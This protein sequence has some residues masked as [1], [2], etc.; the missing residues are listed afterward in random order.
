MYRNLTL[1]VFVVAIS[2]RLLL[3]WGNSPENAFDNHYRPIALIV[4]TGK[5]PAKDDCFQ[6]YQPPV[7]YYSSAMAAKTLINLGIT[8]KEIIEKILQFINCIYVI[9]TIPL[10]YLILKKFGLSETS[11]LIAFSL[12]CFLPR[13]IFMSAM[14]SNDSLAYLGVSLCTYLLLVTIERG[15]PWPLA[16]LLGITVTLTIFVKYTAL[17]VLPMVAVPL[18]SLLFIKSAIPRAKTATAI[19]LA[20]LVPLI[21]YGNYM[22][23]NYR[24]YGKVLPWNDTMINTS[25]VQPHDQDWVSFASFT[26]WQYIVEPM[27]IPG[28]MHSFWTLVYSGMWVDNEPHFTQMTDRNVWW[29]DYFS[30]LR[31]GAA[32]PSSTI[33]LS[34]LTRT[35]TAG[36]LIC[37][38][39]PLVLILSG[40]V[41]CM[42]TIISKPTDK[43]VM[44]QVF[45]VMLFFNAVGIIYLVLKA[46]VYSSMKASYFLN[47]LPAFCVF[48]ANG[49]QDIEKLIWVKRL[50]VLVCSAIILLTSLYIIRI[51]LAFK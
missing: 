37:G 42:F 4:Q 6:C 10:T 30:W 51:F 28:Q 35:I 2:L 12:I 21:L 13:H 15:L 7:F 22:F 14:H 45:P 39:I 18:A 16:C 20:L 36:L 48:A 38:L 17:I 43:T 41:R 46:P 26:P 1:V 47:S 34:I 49:V 25:V 3:C 24:D 11:R 44:L 29:R 40:F 50:I 8:D 31:G 27:V 9:L 5:I 32:F 19:L 23:N 33:P